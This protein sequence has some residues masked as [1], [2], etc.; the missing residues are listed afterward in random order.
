V[1]KPSTDTIAVDLQNNPFRNDQGDILFRPGGH[2]SL[3]ENLNEI[4]AD[5][6]FIKNIDNVAPDRVKINTN[7]FKKLIAG[8]L[9]DFQ[10]KIFNYT[11]IIEEENPGKNTLVEICD[12]L[13]H[14]G[15]RFNKKDLSGLSEDEI[16]KKLL[17]QL[18][19]PVRICGMVKN[20]GEPGGGPFWVIDEYS[21]SS[22]QIVE[23]SQIDLSDYKQK[24]ILN[25]STHFNPVDLVCG[26]KDRKGNKYDLLKFTD[27]DTG[28][29][30]EKSAG[31]RPVKAQELPG[32]WNGAMAHWNT[33]FVEV[34]IETFTPV[35]TVNDLLR[36]EHQALL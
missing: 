15:C 10:E 12:F 11:R 13:K 22:L 21:N 5:L 35:K 16:R 25:N 2:G 27:P 23:T 31:G 30:S 7:S 28:F 8:V 1:Q 33:L 18:R 9:L 17:S 26:I 3:L 6:I 20:E 36:L 19:R 14:G 24:E 32:L 4:D 29:I 34:P